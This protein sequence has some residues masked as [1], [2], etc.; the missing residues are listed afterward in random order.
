[1][2]NVSLHTYYDK[3]IDVIVY[4]ITYSCQDATLISYTAKAVPMSGTA[5]AVHFNI[6]QDGGIAVVTTRKV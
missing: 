5:F 6:Y 2:S 1:M 3:F 4:P